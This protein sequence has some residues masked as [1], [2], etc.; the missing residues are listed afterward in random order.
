MNPIVF[1]MRR[2]IITLML[3]VALAGGGVLGLS[4]MGV[5]I[6]PPLNMRADSR[7]S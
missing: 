6:L 2:P 1:A 7:L 5:D 3:V 4:K